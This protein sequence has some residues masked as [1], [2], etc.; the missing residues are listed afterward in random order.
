MFHFK[1]S[2]EDNF[3][4]ILF[5]R[6]HLNSND[7]FANLYFFLSI[8]LNNETSNKLAEMSKLS[9][10]NHRPQIY[11]VNDSRFLLT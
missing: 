10:D 1:H 4:N 7:L 3:E 11:Q 9:A 2:N 5:L 8:L 6:K